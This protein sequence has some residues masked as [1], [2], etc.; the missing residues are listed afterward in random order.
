MDITDPE[1]EKKDK[2]LDPVRATLVRE[3]FELYSTGNYSL[4]QLAKIMRGKGL[5]SNTKHRTP[6]TRTS[7]EHILKN[8]FYY[9]EMR[10]KGQ[11]Y[12]HNYEP[13]IT[14][15]LFN[16]CEDVRQSW[17]KK[18]FKHGSKPYTFRG[19]I[20]CA[21][22]GCTITSDRKK[23]KY[24]YLACTGHRGDCGAVRVREEV[25]TEQI[26]EVMKQFE[27]PKD[28]LNEYKV[29]LRTSNETEYVFHQAIIS[30]AT[31]KIV[32]IKLRK[33][34]AY[35]DKL[36]KRITNDE[37][38]NLCK[39]WDQEL[40]KLETEIIEH[41]RAHKEF[42][43]ALSNLLDI[44]SRANELFEISKPEQKR[45]LVNFIFSNLKL[46]GKKLVF[47]LKMPFD[48]MALLSKSENWLRGLDSNQD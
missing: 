17:H 5:T 37:Y 31:D 21:F 39:E 24:T 7:I 41:S 6:A 13:I 40:D 10:V 26:Q 48:Q 20:K 4:R 18:P 9:G 32:I 45:Q 38:D 8:P 23:D 35:N 28:T 3:A 11:L 42:A 12:K 43:I 47:N 2:V 15:W 44:A 1:T 22:C 19:L 16:K 36:D 34:E 29:F 33:K 14:K 46:E 27:M 30:E 25:I